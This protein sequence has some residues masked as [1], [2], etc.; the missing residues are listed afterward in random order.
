MQKVDPTEFYIVRHG[1]TAANLAAVIQGQRDT[2][3]D[4]TGQKQIQLLG[5]FLK[6]ETFDIVYA[7]DLKRTRDTA[8]AIMQY[9]PDLPI[10]FTSELRE[11]DLG[12]LEGKSYAELDIKYPVLMQNIRQSSRKS[13]PPGGETMQQFL[14]RITRFMENTARKH[15]GKKILLVTHG[16]VIQRIFDLTFGE[17][18]SG[19]L[20]PLCNNASLSVFLNKNQRWQLACWNNTA[21]LRGI[22]PQET[23]TL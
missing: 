10:E 19:N 12:E 17:T 18:A 9:H 3:L 8:Q 4:E 2:L 14:E 1:Q 21:F 22:A 7:S 11:W 15:A 13:A 5:D 23:L 6:E 20:R 16:G